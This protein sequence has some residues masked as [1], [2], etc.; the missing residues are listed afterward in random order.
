MNTLL[1]NIVAFVPLVVVMSGI[2][3]ML[4]DHWVYRRR[5]NHH[6]SHQDTIQQD[7]AQ[8]HSF[9]VTHVRAGEILHD[10]F[11]RHFQS[12]RFQQLARSFIGNALAIVAGWLL[13][14]ILDPATVLPFLHR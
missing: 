2:I 3:T 4:A 1:Q 11:D 6:A 7:F 9:L 5:A 12:S 8:V 14:A 10:Y 13:S